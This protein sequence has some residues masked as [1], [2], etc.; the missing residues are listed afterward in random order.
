[1]PPTVTAYQ[2]G[3]ALLDAVQC[4]SYPESE[5]I[6][7]ADFPPSAFPQALELLSS[8]L[9]EVKTRLRKSSKHSAQDIDGWISQAKQ[10]RND[11]QTVRRSAEEIVSKAKQDEELQQALHDAGSKLR[12]LEEEVAFNQT[13]TTILEQIRGIRRDIKQAHNLVNEAD[14]STAA[15]FLLDIDT[16]LVSIQR[17]RNIKAL[18]V[19][20][21]E[22]R[23]LRQTVARAL[24]QSDPLSKSC[25]PSLVE[26]LISVR[27]SAAVPQELAA[28]QCFN[29]TREEVRRFSKTMDDH[30]W[31]GASRLR[32]WANSIPQIWLEKRQ[33]QCLE[34]VRQLLRRGLGD[35][36]TVERVETQKVSQQDSLF[37]TSKGND[38][39]NAEWSEE[40]ER[41]FGPKQVESSNASADTE[42]EDVRA[43]GL[44]DG[45]DNRKTEDNSPVG[46][47]DD[48]ADAW[49]WGDDWD[50]DEGS[51]SPQRNSNKPA[52]QGVNGYDKA[53]RGSEREITLRES[54]N[55]TSLPLGILD[56]IN[57][58]VADA[59]AI[60]TQR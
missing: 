57:S 13:L 24:T 29:S 37:H 53:Q 41:S 36:K 52:R 2:L 9:E 49:G 10:L 23:E 42:E 5:A 20:E 17:G 11:I 51:R 33:R 30:G 59:Y 32:A 4:N 35:I 15:K 16:D 39:W 8:A 28:L 3:E 58:I 48:E 56:L 34:Q 18:A 27:L 14:L 38:D 43:W 40:E 1:M 31:P 21:L 6:I 26:S 47:K 54:Y 50:D 55:I 7:S 25:G 46:G 12:L 19:V 60:S 44:D 45:K 22:S